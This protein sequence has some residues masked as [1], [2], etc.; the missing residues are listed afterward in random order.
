VLE[1]AVNLRPDRY[2]AHAGLAEVSIREQSLEQAAWQFGQ[3]LERAGPLVGR[4]ELDKQV[5]LELYRQRARVRAASADL[6]PDRARQDEAARAALADLD[7]AVRLARRLAPGK[8]LAQVRLQRGLVLRQLRRHQEALAAYCAALAITPSDPEAWRWRAEAELQLRL[9][10]DALK[11]YGRYFDLGGARS[12]EIYQ[13]QAVARLHTRDL[14]GAL[15]DYTSALALRPD[16]PTGLLVQRGQIYLADG[17][18]ALAE[19]DFNDVIARRG[20]ASQ[21]DLGH[22]LLGRALCRLKLPRHEYEQAA[23]D[24][25]QAVAL[26]GDNA[27]A[28]SRAAGLF[29]QAAAQ[30]GA[31]AR[32][33]RSAAGLRERY[34][35]RA[36]R[37]LRQAVL[38]QPEDRRRSFWRR[39]IR[40]DRSLDPVR[41]RAE[42]QRLDRWFGGPEEEK[43]TGRQAGKGK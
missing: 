21:A 7:E 33:R 43:G 32:A 38:L 5:L 10:E 39:S 3:A 26:L 42:F 8:V 12:A 41:R 37:L 17:A 31:D 28:L 20:Q 2:E 11:S 4:G 19:R 40:P 9:Y 22:A 29:A 14:R 30:A 15:D 35:D 27:E 6:Y 23:A 18:S 16:N 36:L 24:A 13:R 25:E 34:E 1:E